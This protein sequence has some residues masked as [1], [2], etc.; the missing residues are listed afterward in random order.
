MN[1]ICGEKHLGL[2][3]AMRIIG[4][5]EA[6]YWFSYLVLFTLT[7]IA[8]ALIAAAIM[9]L[10]QV[11][12]FRDTNYGVSA[13]V[14]FFFIVSM[15][16]VGGFFSSFVSRPVYTNLISFFLFAMVALLGL[17]VGLPGLDPRYGPDGSL[18]TKIFIAF[19]PWLSFMRVWS[20]I[21][22]KIQ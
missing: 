22:V 8:G 1:T 16:S 4:L 10:T 7:A 13:L 20:V 15:S 18:I 5:S 19:C 2:T 11:T 14:T 17:I 12:L 3:G 9:L 21:G 6:A